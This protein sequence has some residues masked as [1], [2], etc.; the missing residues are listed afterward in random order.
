[1]TPRS[2]AAAARVLWRTFGARG[3]ARRASF[4]ARSVAGRFRREPDA[5]PPAVG[6]LAVPPGWPFR[7]DGER[8]RAATDRSAALCR[9]GRVLSGVHQAYRHEWRPLP[10]SA[11]GWRTHPASGKEYDPAVPWFRVPHFDARAG[12]IKDVW[13]PARF[14]W[15]YDLSRGWLITRD[16]RYAGEF[17]RRFET[18]LDGCAPFHGVQWACGQETAIR[19]IALLWAEGALHDA[20]SS[21][22]AR[23]A[24]LRRALAWSGERI[25]NA[26]G[27]ALSQR[28]N[29]GISEA[30][31][32]VAIGARLRGA[33]PRAERW[34]R[35]GARWLEEQVRDQFELDG[36]YL[37]HSFNYA[38][39]ALDQLVVAQLA[40]NIVG[41]SL[42]DEALTRIRAAVALI[43]ACVEP[44]TGE[45]PLHGAND[46]AYVLPLS[47]RPY[48][49]FIPGLTAAGSVFGAGLPARLTPDEETLAWLGA[50]RPQLDA[51][52]DGWSVRSG[53]SGWVMID[54]GGARLFARAGAYRS[55][56][57]HI[58]PLHVDVW[59]DGRLVATDAGTY[60]YAADPPWNNGLA[61]AE[62]HNTVSL[63]GRPAARRGPRFL[64][65]GWPE[66]RVLET[67]HN[68]E[69]VR[70]TL[71]NRSW[72]RE[73][74][75]H[76]RHC[77]VGPSGV[78]VLDEISAPPELEVPVALCWLIDG[79]PDEVAVAASVPVTRTDRAG[80]PGSVQGW[81][82]EHYAA[83]RPATSV[84]VEGRLRGGM[85]RIATGF[86]D[87]RATDWLAA[88]T[89]GETDAVVTCSI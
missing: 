12:D 84:R 42:S 26:I 73:G 34:L 43:A 32:L 13:E 30:A 6:A 27:Y 66:A 3:V 25:E 60:R 64:W 85:M 48:R 38:R 14:A 52:R 55:R 49:D 47:T 87:R 7:V 78:S 1:M 23:L 10:D 61:A 17:W 59:I 4:E 65:L 36:W 11:R 44:S 89:L 5:V 31:A 15:A 63:P 75:R 79:P 40:L 24:S 62:A 28:N 2:V 20:A 76:L 33:D 51:A 77:E 86:G 80:D 56:P 71:E 39:V 9:A 69:T 19:A 83:K 41:R 68:R 88:L 67:S 57:G 53:P 70:V 45:P 21:S 37:Q 50:L 18:F 81:I 74:I 8:V 58:D 22:P 72:A 54:T 35:E 29:H 16:D 82:S 46:G